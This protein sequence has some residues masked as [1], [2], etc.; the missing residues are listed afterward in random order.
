[1]IYLLGTDH[2]LQ[3]D[4]NNAM[5]HDFTNYLESE[6]IKISAVLIAEEWF[7]EMSKRNGVLTTTVQDVAT[8]LHINH[9][10]CDPDPA[11]R[12]RIG[13]YSIADNHLR[14]EYWFLK[15]K[16]RADQAVLFVCG[17]DHLS[18]FPSVL[19]KNNVQ[20]QILPVRFCNPPVNW[21]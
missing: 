18:T 6:A 8:R 11:E 20:S 21:C 15:I 9:R 16:D 14:E 5:T 3:H 12:K 13:Y 19:A 4:R 17:C 7:D 1:M 10:H 2:Q